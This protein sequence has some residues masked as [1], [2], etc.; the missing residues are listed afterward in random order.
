MILYFCTRTYIMSTVHFYKNTPVVSS[1][2]T[3]VSKLGWCLAN[4]LVRIRVHD[5]NQ[6]NLA[7]WRSISLHRGSKPWSLLDL[8][9]EL[10]ADQ[11][12]VSLVAKYLGA[13]RGWAGGVGLF[14]NCR[15]EEDKW[16]VGD[17][18]PGATVTLSENRISIPGSVTC[19]DQ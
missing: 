2:V 14:T 5:S 6:P 15:W 3:D 13:D 7:G 19:H 12:L 4:V 9:P 8:G 17:P 11:V 1:H 10:H 16:P 18:F